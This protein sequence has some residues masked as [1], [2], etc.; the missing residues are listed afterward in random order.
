MEFVQGAVEV[1]QAGSK[2]EEANNIIR[3]ESIF[4]ALSTNHAASDEVLFFSLYCC[5]AREDVD[6]KQMDVD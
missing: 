1:R 6:D 5:C 4:S 3:G 2:Q